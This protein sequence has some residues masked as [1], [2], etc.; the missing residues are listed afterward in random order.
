MVCF[1]LAKSQLPAAGPLSGVTYLGPTQ[2]GTQPGQ[3][4]PAACSGGGELIEGGIST[5]PGFRHVSQTYETGLL[6][7]SKNNYSNMANHCLLKL[8]ATVFCLSFQQ[9]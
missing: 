5:A 7:K 9:L 2:E 8:Q 1:P 4:P 3:E 6:V